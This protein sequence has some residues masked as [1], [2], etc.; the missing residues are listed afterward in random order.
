MVRR[1]RPTSISSHPPSRTRRWSPLGPR[2][3]I[4]PKQRK[5]RTIKESTSRHR[6]TP[7]PATLRRMR[8]SPSP[9]HLQPSSILPFFKKNTPESAVPVWPSFSR[10]WLL[11]SLLK[12]ELEVDWV[13]RRMQ[14]AERSLRGCLKSCVY[15]GSGSLSRLRRGDSGEVDKDTRFMCFELSTCYLVIWYYFCCNTTPSFAVLVEV[16][17][18]SYQSS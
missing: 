2:S 4:P 17:Y 7:R 6:K 8:P 13:C 18:L 16:S 14:P 12:W 11:S 5:I 1:S 3:K 15:P 10:H 9:S